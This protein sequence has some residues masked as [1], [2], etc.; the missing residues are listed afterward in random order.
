MILFDIWNG[1]TEWNTTHHFGRIR[2]AAEWM[3]HTEIDRARC[4]ETS[5]EKVTEEVGSNGLDFVDALL[6]A[7]YVRLNREMETTEMCSD[8]HGHP[9]DGS[10]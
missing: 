4:Q 7:D 3:H 2:I 8:L 10:T 9:C 6:N 5:D 1:Y